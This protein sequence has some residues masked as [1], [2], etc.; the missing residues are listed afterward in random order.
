MPIALSVAAALLFAVGGL[1]MKYSNGMTR[2]LPGVAVLLLFCCGATCQA[3]AMKRSDMGPVY[4]LVLGLEAVTAFLL[5]MVVLGERATLARVF[6][7]V[8]I[9]A[10]IVLL[11][12]A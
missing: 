6:A 3:V 9:A 2:F 12:R 4:I 8:L 11:E 10:G 5:S 1:F 7:I